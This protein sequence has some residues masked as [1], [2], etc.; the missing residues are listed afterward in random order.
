MQQIIFFF[1]RNKNFLLFLLLFVIS[2]TLTINS[3][4]YHKNKFVTSANFLSGGVYSM[5][6]SVTN[7]FDLEEQNKILTEENERLRAILANREVETPLE[8]PIDTNYN[9]ISA[10]VINNNYARTKNYLTLNKGIRDSLKVDMGVIS[11]Q[12]VVG[13][14][15]AVSNKYASVQSVLNTNSQVVAKF[16]KSDQFGTLKWDAEKANIVQLIEIPRLADVAVGDTIVTDGKSTIFPEGILIGTVADFERK[17]D[18]DYYDINVQ[19]FSDMTRVKH[20]Y[21]ISHRDAVEIKQLEKEVED[22]E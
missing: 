11:S 18:Q 3:H 13:I 16:K 8:S 4:S 22:A 10:K 2:F 1:L 12:G 21:V 5:K 15:N 6:S 7:Y 19:L 14:I 9:F 17:P 20:V